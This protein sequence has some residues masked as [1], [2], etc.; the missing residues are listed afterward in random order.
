VPGGGGGVCRAR[1]GIHESTT[2]RQRD[3]R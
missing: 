3:T 1:A 2:P